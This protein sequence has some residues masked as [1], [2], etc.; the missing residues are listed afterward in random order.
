MKITKWKLIGWEIEYRNLNECT[1]R[2]QWKQSNCEWVHNFFKRGAKVDALVA[3]MNSMNGMNRNRKW[4]EREWGMKR[5]RRFFLFTQRT[6]GLEPEKRR[7]SHSLFSIHKNVQRNTFFVLSS[8]FNFFPFFLFSILSFL[9]SSSL[10]F[11][12]P[13]FSL[14]SFH[15]LSPFESLWMETYYVLPDTMDTNIQ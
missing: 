7:T 1:F 12:L 10:F 6:S 11:S 3:V 15:P 14:A 9:L 5:K 13:S 4:E 2:I 8:Q